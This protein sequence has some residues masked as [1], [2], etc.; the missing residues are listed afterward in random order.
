MDAIGGW[1]ALEIKERL[2]KTFGGQN[3]L[4]DSKAI[5]IAIRKP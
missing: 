3:S 1:E 5:G 2:L 4:S